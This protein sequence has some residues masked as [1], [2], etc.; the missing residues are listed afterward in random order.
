MPT[1]RRRPTSSIRSLGVAF[2][3]LAVAWSVPAS[4]KE[5]E[6]LPLDLHAK[7]H[8]TADASIASMTYAVAAAHLPARGTALLLAGGAAM[9]VGFGKEFLDLSTEGRFGWRDIAW[10]AIGT[11]AGLGL[12]WGLDVLI[13]GGDERHP[14][15]FSPAQGGRPAALLRF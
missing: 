3:L 9:A 7:L 8:F 4:A 14:L 2:A 13:R 10:D 1:R 15:F 11:A 12:A 5:E 6:L